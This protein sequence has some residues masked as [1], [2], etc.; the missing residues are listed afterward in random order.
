[1]YSTQMRSAFNAARPSGE[2]CSQVVAHAASPGLQLA[3]HIFSASH[4]VP[5]AHADVTAAQR[6]DS[7][8]AHAE[9]AGCR[10][11]R[12]ATFATPPVSP[13]TCPLE[14]PVAPLPPLGASKGVSPVGNVPST[15]PVD[16]L[17]ANVLQRSREPSEIVKI[18]TLF[19]ASFFRGGARV[20][21][22]F[23][24]VVGARNRL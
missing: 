18:E 13:E 22:P 14:S 7:H 15:G 19:M 4:D 17:H 12:K 24:G 5:G 8:V 6:S 10:D 2:S 21:M 9:S 23:I 11:S 20:C 1:L 3:R 16:A